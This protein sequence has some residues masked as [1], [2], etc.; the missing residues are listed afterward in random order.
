M[1]EW[2]S[3]RT[4]YGKPGVELSKKAES[5]NS[6]KSS[7]QIKADSPINLKNKS[8]R[9]KASQRVT[10]LSPKLIATDLVFQELENVARKIS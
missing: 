2:T 3:G 1:V 4:N 5:P 7:C 6:F 9:L 8:H 10:F